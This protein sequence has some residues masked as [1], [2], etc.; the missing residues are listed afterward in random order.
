MGIWEWPYNAELV[1]VV[2]CCFPQQTSTVVILLCV[3]VQYA[4]LVSRK[5]T[6]VSLRRPR[7]GQTARHEWRRWS[8][9][10]DHCCG[11]SVMHVW[12]RCLPQQITVPS[13]GHKLLS[14]VTVPMDRRYSYI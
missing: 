10:A 12:R 8:P 1:T 2:G 14:I 6:L 5:E 9:F 4:Q 7:C 3:T 13:D 11:Q